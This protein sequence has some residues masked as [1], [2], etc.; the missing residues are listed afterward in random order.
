MLHELRSSPP[1][2]L[3][4]DQHFRDYILA[5]WGDVWYQMVE[6]LELSWRKVDFHVGCMLSKV[7]KD[8]FARCPQYVMNLI[9]LVELIISREQRT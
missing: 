9:N 2:I 1:L 8:F 6:S 7:I 3:V 5:V 4:V